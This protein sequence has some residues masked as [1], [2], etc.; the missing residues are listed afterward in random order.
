MSDFV[1]G[2]THGYMSL[3]KLSH[4]NW[5]DGAELTLDDHVFIAGDFGL[6]F[7]NIQSRD[8]IYYLKWL[9]SCPWTTLVIDGNHENHPKLA[10]LPQKEWC[11][12][13]VGIIADNILHLKRGEVYTINGKTYF[14]FGGARSEDKMF[15]K[16]HISWWEEELPSMEELNNGIKNLEGI[17]YTVDYVIT[18]TAPYSI[19]NKYQDKLE[20]PTCDAYGLIN[21]FDLILERLKFNHW[22]FGHFHHDIE[23]DD[24]F[25][26]I[27]HHIIK[28]EE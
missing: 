9:A 21:Y 19:I 1:T 20:I 16:E 6:I 10:A 26:A 18:H 7:N 2:D 23:L 22:Y 25:T 5:K 13:K 3:M 4:N 15:R 28:L 24:K 14:I 27:Y 17:N 11:G 8:E 12:G